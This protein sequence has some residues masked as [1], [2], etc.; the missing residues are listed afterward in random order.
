[1]I[2]AR[3]VDALSWARLAGRLL[4]RRNPAAAADARR[5]CARIRADIAA[6]GNPPAT[7]A[8]IARRIARPE[9]PDVPDR[10]GVWILRTPYGVSLHYV[11]HDPHGLCVDGMGWIGLHD[12][13]RQAPAPVWCG[14]APAH[15]AEAHYRA[16]S[17]RT[18]LSDARAARAAGR[19]VNPDT[20]ARA[21]RDLALC[22]F[23]V[24]T[25]RD[26]EWTR[27]A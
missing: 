20:I 17:V 16:F 5:E 22:G 26:V 11:T 18:T 2:A 12:T 1:M 15:V 9:S 10:A 23:I 4:A 3:D 27:H 8:D 7:L 13:A 19:P 21:D 14:R 24:A 6:R 25:F